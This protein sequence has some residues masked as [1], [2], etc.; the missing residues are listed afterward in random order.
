MALE[1]V[2]LVKEATDLVGLIGEVTEVKGGPAPPIEYSAR[3]TPT[4]DTPSVGSAERAAAVGQD[5]L[6]DV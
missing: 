2:A 4:R 1:V 6:A 3:S 5:T